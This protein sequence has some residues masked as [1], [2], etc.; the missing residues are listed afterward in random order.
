ME[1]VASLLE[2][3]GREE[4]KEGIKGLVFAL[5]LLAYG[6]DVEGEVRDLLR[7]MDAKGIVEAK[8]G[9]VAKEDQVLL[10]EVMKIVT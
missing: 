2:A 8:M 5:G 9:S 3:I 6:C 10:T 7:A 4:S 1:L